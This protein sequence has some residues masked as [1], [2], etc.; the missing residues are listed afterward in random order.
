MP[1][2][3]A[4]KH[5]PR[6]PTP[7][8]CNKEMAPTQLPLRTTLV[9]TWLQWYLSGGFHV[10][11]LQSNMKCGVC[12]RKELHAMSCCQVARPCLSDVESQ[13]PSL[14]WLSSVC[15]KSGYVLLDD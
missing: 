8:P 9:H 3:D 12:I 5:Y 14:P 4:S 7:E 10:I 15:V 6:A 1:S 13:L 11:S 2:G